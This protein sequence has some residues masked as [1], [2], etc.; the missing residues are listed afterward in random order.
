MDVVT[1][2][3]QFSQLIHTVSGSAEIDMLCHIQ[4]ND[5][6]WFLENYSYEP[7]TY[8]YIQANIECKLADNNAIHE[9]VNLISNANKD[10]D[11]ECIAN[12][13]IDENTDSNAND[14]NTDADNNIDINAI[15]ML[16]LYCIHLPV[17]FTYKCIPP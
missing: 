14:T 12:E 8:S 9:F 10:T 16:I 5:A 15:A 17:Y 4:A 13:D 6:Q 11:N 3:S 1:L 2:L 7:F